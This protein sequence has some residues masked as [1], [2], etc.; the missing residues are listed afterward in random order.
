MKK[1][2]LALSCAFIF[3]TGCAST[4][5]TANTATRGLLICQANEL[6]PIVTVAWNES[7]KDRLK[8][9]MSL[10]STYTKYNIQKVILTDGVNKHSFNV[11]DLTEMDVAFGA[12]R[13]RNSVIIPVSIMDDFNGSKEVKMEI[14]TDQGVISRYVLKD[15]VKA[16]VFEELLKVYK[17]SA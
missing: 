8:V 17:K 5:P 16:P 1:K 13:S 6:C 11:T 10:N 12:N 3:M 9:K 7:S 15:K 14:Y 4:P 2:L